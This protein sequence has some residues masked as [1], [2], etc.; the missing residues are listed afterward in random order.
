VYDSCLRVGYP[1]GLGDMGIIIASA[2]LGWLVVAVVLLL[3]VKHHIRS[4]DEDIAFLC[5][6]GVLFWPIAIPIGL[7]IGILV[8]LTDW[9]K[10][11]GGE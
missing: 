11:E 8:L 7:L 3:L 10:A 6:M 5:I 2:V 9:L 4:E 1:N